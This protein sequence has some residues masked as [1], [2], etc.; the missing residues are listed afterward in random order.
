MSLTKDDLNQVRD[1]V[2]SAIEALVIPRFDEIE[3]RF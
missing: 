1:V 3:K 2:V